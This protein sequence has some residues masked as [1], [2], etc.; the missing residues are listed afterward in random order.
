M[1]NYKFYY[2]SVNTA[3]ICP[4]EIR[5]FRRM[6]NT[7]L[8]FMN[9]TYKNLSVLKKE[10]IATLVAGIFSFVIVKFYT[11]GRIKFYISECTI[12][13]GPHV[14]VNLTFA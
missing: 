6:E 4:E 5:R 7:L 2:E 8:P 9:K 1:D 11:D 12:L 14:K 3:G 10:N 13:C